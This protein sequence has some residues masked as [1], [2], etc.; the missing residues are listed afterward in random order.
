MG[1]GA[2]SGGRDDNMVSCDW[3]IKK[4]NRKWT[5]SKRRGFPCAASSPS[6]AGDITEFKLK[7]APSAIFLMLS[8]LFFFHF[9]LPASEG[10]FL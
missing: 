3:R 7:A 2:G 10:L 5:E 4:W 9:F 8:N 6:D 1:V